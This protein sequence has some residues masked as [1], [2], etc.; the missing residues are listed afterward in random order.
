MFIKEIAKKVF[1]NSCKNFLRRN[2]NRIKYRDLLSNTQKHYLSVI[3][4]IKNRKDKKIKIASYVVFDSTFGAS[5]IISL[6]QKEPNK[7]TYKFIICPDVSRGQEHLIEQ[8]NQTKSFFINK[9][10][11]EFV[12]DGYDIKTNS[13][14]DYSDQF[15]IVY[16]ANPYDAM[17]TKVHQVSYLSTKNILPIYISYGCMPDKYGCENVMAI[18][19]ISLFW[20]VFADN[21][22]SYLDYK[23]YELLCGKNIVCS[24][25]AKMDDLE[26]YTKI[27]SNKKRIIIAPHHTVANNIFPLSNFLSYY[28]LILE[29]P[30]L[31][32]NIDFIFRPHPLLFTNLVNQNIW[33]KEDVTEYLQ[34]IKDCGIEYS[35]GGDYLQLLKNSDAMI[36]DCSSFLVEYLYTEN[37][38]CY[39]MR[40]KKTTKLFASLGKKCLSMCELAYNKEDII[41]FIKKIDK[42]EI[43][44]KDNSFINDNI[45]INYPNVSKK[46]VEIIEKEVC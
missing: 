23:K 12:L 37:P 11:K 15:D 32:P 36:H 39:V 28:K 19:E 2:I 34:Q 38:C 6:M 3:E 44:K 16:C 24:G 18:K 43:T 45:K 1:P 8:Y 40:S 4:K 9:Y 41:S 29:L 27:K 7:W 14:I 25:Y 20:K 22:Q 17:V 42:E 31:F 5:N 10:G 13:F 33:S 46:I 26:N 30:T 35:V 21:K